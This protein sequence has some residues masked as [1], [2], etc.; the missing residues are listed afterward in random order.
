MSKGV[1]WILTN[2][3]ITHFK[4][5]SLER[6]EAFI[7]CK[8][9]IKTGPV[10]SWFE[11][12]SIFALKWRLKLLAIISQFT[13]FFFKPSKTHVNQKGKFPGNMV[14]M[15]SLA[16]PVKKN[17]QTKKPKHPQILIIWASDSKTTL[18]YRRKWPHAWHYQ[19]LQAFFAWSLFIPKGWQLIFS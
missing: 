6:S 3:V 11:G 14:L 16:N 5:Q 15:D 18:Q 9:D 12:K 7:W 19:L 17:K 1:E 4:M 13:Y 2:V 8:L 10:V